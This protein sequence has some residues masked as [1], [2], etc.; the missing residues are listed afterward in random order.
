MDYRIIS[1]GALSV[2]EIWD[3]QGAPRTAHATT[4]LIRSGDRVILVDPA[5]PPQAI[6]ARLSERAGLQA[7]DI[8]DVFLTNFRP[9]HRGGL[10][11]FGQAKWWISEAERESVGVSL[12]EKFEHEEDEEVREI[13]RR[14]VSLLQKFANAP[15]T[16]AEHVDL[17]PLPGFTPG[18]CGLLLSEM[19]RTIIVAG[20]A[21]ASSEHFE[22]GRVLRGAMD[23]EAAKA[24]L[25]EVLE[26]ADV[27]IPGH[28]NLI[29]HPGRRGSMGPMM[30]QS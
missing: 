5:L 23:I 6:A 19:S 10:G 13:L 17:F 28:D 21:V 22:H 9:S 30:S 12:I 3:K 26:I 11:A 25:G 4:T 8:T 20:D 29:L 7:S 1:I 15:D 14:E 16:L 18:T 27:V 2:H 24:S